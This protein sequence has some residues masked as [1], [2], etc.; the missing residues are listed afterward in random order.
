MENR[1]LPEPRTST[2]PPLRR[3]SLSRL[4]VV[5]L[6]V[7]VAL[8]VAACGGGATPEPAAQQPAVV[9]QIVEREVER[10]VVVTA[11][12]EPTPDVGAEP[13]TL[14]FTTWTGNEQHL[15]VL[16][17]IAAAYKE[18]HPNVTVQY[19]TIPTDDYPT[20]LAVQLAGGNPPD[21]GWMPENLAL[22]FL[23]AG[24][25]ADLKPAIETTPEFNYDDLIEPAMSLYLRDGG[26]Y[27]IPFSTSPMLTFFNRDLFEQAGIETPDALYARGE[28]TWDALEEAAKAI[29]DATPQ[30]VYGFE[31][32]EGQLYDIRW[33][34][35][36]VPL[37]WAYGGGT[38]DQEG[39]QCL[40]NAP[41]SVE[42]F[43]KFHNM[44][45]VDRSVVPPGEQADFFSGNAG[46]TFNFLSAV[47]KL[48]N[49]PFEWGIVPLPSG[50]AGEVSVIGQS[51]IVAFEASKHKEIA[52]DFVL[53]MT[54]EENVA[55]LAQFFP[56]IRRSVLSSDAL[57]EANPLVSPE[58]MQYV[59]QGI[60]T[61]QLLPPHVEFNKID[62][63]VQAELDNLFRPDADVE[64]SLNATCQAIAQYLGS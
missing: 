49:A 11:T 5:F 45:F 20:K 44:I 31:G 2:R 29:A 7:L 24:A 64:A 50:P 30:G 38:W 41:E 21:A 26:V 12:P 47:G 3:R 28:W 40:F 61:G 17:E 18:L 8:I 51:S 36:L 25:L 15:A 27:G 13:V 55:R 14:R 48:G 22:P 1:L 10:E 57:I 56:P 19:D 33:H 34:H 6:L 60:E 59:V 23:Q 58:Q 16:N 46:M 32:R 4:S 63:A 39:T 43:Q 53:F 9:T 54:N 42:A 37:L 35:T 52:I 62:L